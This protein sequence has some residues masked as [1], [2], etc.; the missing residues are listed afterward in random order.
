MLAAKSEESFVD[1][2]QKKAGRDALG[3][4]Y[5][6]FRP[7]PVMADEARIAHTPHGNSLG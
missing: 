7:R 6:G 2:I 5:G 4:G 3:L 1:G